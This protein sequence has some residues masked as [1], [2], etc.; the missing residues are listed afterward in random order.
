MF[1]SL[2]ISLNGKPVTLHE[3]NYHYKTYLEK[4]LN[5]VF[6]ASGTHLVSSFRY[7]DLPGELNENSGYVRRLDYL[8]NGK[9]IELYGR[10]HADLFDSDKMLI[11]GIGMNTKLKCA[12]ESFYLL[13]SSDDNKVRV[14]ILYASLFITKD[15][16]KPHL[17]LSNANV[18]AMLRK[19]HYPVTHTQIETFTAKSGAQ[20][21]STDK[22]FLGPVPERILIAFVKNTAFV[23]SAF[24]N[25]FHFHHCDMTN[26]VLFVNGVQ[27]PSEPLTVDFSSPFGDNRA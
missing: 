2:S 24:T 9:T 15:D 4:L 22:T 26:F 19:A 10:L 17:L 6:D 5:Y 13:A 27:N 7:L 1:S 25:P 23:V 14:K 18:L 16:L 20:Q 8:R 3:T 11:N 12:P 21:F